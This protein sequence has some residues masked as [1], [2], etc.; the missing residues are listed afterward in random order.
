LQN[1]RLTNRPPAGSYT[2]DVSA[3]GRINLCP[4]PRQV[5][6]QGYNQTAVNALVV[7]D[8]KA[9]RGEGPG[10]KPD[11]LLD[12]YERQVLH[13]PWAFSVAANE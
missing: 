6:R 10:I 4:T 5:Y 8:L 12:D 13:G 9:A 2:I 11:A 3:D 7:G 1:P